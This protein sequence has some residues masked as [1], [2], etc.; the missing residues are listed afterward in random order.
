MTSTSLLTVPSILSEVVTPEAFAQMM[1]EVDS[2]EAAYRAMTS[3]PVVRV[4]ENQLLDLIVQNVSGC[5][6]ASIYAV[7]MPKLTVKH[8]V[9]LKPLSDFI[10]GP[11]VC[12]YGWNFPLGAIYERLVNRQ[13]EREGL[14]ADF[15]AGAFAN[16]AE[17]INKYAIRQKNTGNICLCCA[18]IGDFNKAGDGQYLDGNGNAISAE[19]M[20]ELKVG[21]MP[22]EK[23]GSGRQG[24][25]TPV[26]FKTPA[27]KNI[28]Y[29]VM[30]GVV[31]EVFHN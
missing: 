4:S 20:A 9:N 12:L 29:L 2:N 3:K 21:F 30:G 17:H 6:M 31:W 5:T 8:R 14:T 22:K 1:A 11:L 7:T 10:V 27:V 16:G 26:I 15:K 28:K 18:S 23:E 25:E 24:T 19:T 13:R